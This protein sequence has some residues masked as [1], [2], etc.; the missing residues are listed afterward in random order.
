[1]YSKTGAQVALFVSFEGGEGSGKTTQFQMLCERLEQSGRRVLPIKE[2]GTTPLGRHV[3]ELVK[4]RPWG[5]QRGGQVIS[6]GAELFLFLAARAEL[7]A[8]VLRQTSEEDN[9]VIV[10]DRYADS[11]VAYQGYGRRLSIAAVE[12]MNRLATGGVMPHLTILLDCAPEVGL[13]RVGAVQIALP[14]DVEE[15]LTAGRLDEEDSRRFEDEPLEFHRR[16]RAGYRAMAANEPDRW[17][18]IDATMAIEGVHEQVWRDVEP[19]LPAVSGA[20]AAQLELHSPTS[21]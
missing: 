3:R 11:T 4:G 21:A 20:P 18:V 6:K 9:L 15:V 16:L 10:A 13:G 5:G 14:L 17:S 2:P 12:E 19:F 1:M 8:K 7:V